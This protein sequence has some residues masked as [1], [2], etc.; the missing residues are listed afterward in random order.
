MV[1]LRVLSGKRAGA[2]FSAAK[3]PI[4]VGRSSESDF[5]LEEQGVWP[6]HFQIVWVNDN[7]EIESQP[8][9]LLE[10][11]GA[12]TQRAPLRN[13]DTITAGGIAI[14]FN[15]SPVRQS[16][17]SLRENLTWVGLAA[18]CAAQAA[19]AWALPR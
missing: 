11:N 2:E 13:G 19:L 3:F 6:Q 10:L 17:L 9:A 12:P 7:L 5:P 1:L 15:L 8:E 14:R 16:S 18:L 4:R